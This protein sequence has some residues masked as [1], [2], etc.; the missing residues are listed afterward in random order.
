MKYKIKCNFLLIK[1]QRALYGLG[2]EGETRSVIY[3]TTKVYTVQYFH[4]YLYFN[5]VKDII[6]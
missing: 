2:F 5:L 6:K 4:D 1:T 3:R